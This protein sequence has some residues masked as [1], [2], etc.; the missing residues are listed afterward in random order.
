MPT[1]SDLDHVFLHVCC[2]PIF[3][4]KHVQQWS[5]HMNTGRMSILVTMKRLW[6]TLHIH[7]I[8][9]LH[10]CMKISITSCPHKFLLMVLVW[11]TA[12]LSPNIFS[13]E[14]S[15][16]L[17]PCSILETEE[18]SAN[19]FQSVLPPVGGHE[20]PREPQK[21]DKMEMA[22]RVRGRQRRMRNGKQTACVEAVRAE[23][24]QGFV[25]PSVRCSKITR[26]LFWRARRLERPFFTRLAWSGVFCRATST[27]DPFYQIPPW[28]WHGGSGSCTT[29][30]IQPHAGKNTNIV[31]IE[32]AME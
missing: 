17:D 11:A 13:M 12:I 24:A 9:D 32:E 3:R 14:P 7:S 19:Q 28:S 5:K 16:A 22:L 15:S 20:V 2:L 31:I 23:S 27:S 4:P 21:L 6:K 1:F 10:H 30:T 8:W 25:D 29:V 18:S 26:D